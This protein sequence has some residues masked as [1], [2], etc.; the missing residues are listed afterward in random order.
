MAH[1][2]TVLSQLIKL[3]PRHDFNRLAKQHRG[4]APELRTTS[5]WDQFV[6]LAVG[7]LGGR[8][9][10]RDI[11]SNLKA[12]AR[13]LY[14]LGTAGIARS[15]LAR[16][17]QEQ[18]PELYQALFAQLYARCQSR[19]PRHPFRFKNK[20]YSI[21]SSLIDLSLSLFPWAHFSKGKGA[22]K[23]HVGLDHDGLLPAFAVITASKCH[24]AHAARAFHLPTGSIAVFDRGYT[25]FRWFN[26]LNEQAVF[27]VTRVR[28]DLAYRV[29]ERHKADRASGISS[30]QT[31]ELT[32]KRAR[33]AGLT[34]LRRVG[35]Y[36]PATKRHYVFLTNHFALS[37][38][39]IAAVYKSRWQVELFFKWIKQNLKIKTFVGHSNNAILTQIWI[40]MCVYLLL[41]YLKFSAQISASLQE[42]L[43]LLQLNLFLPRSLIALFKPHP[44]DPADPPLQPQLALA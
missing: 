5:R 43:R 13:S 24:D 22:L 33:L 16:L 2:S 9:S 39:T 38:T 41:A 15:S 10:L 25:D 26:S 7:Q 42:M 23:L 32:G 19:T 37:A 3:V 18:S 28:R 20:L 34:T 21:D 27:F 11:E 30:D 14:H 40:A 1:S 35:Y 17:N 44:A 4:E 31:I 12:Q 36:D 29:I 8:Q 6:A